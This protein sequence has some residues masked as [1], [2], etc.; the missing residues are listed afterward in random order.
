MFLADPVQGQIK[1]SSSNLPIV[2]INTAQGAAII[3]EPK[4]TADMKIIF[5]GAGK[6]NYVTDPGNVYN[7]KIGIE[8]RG[9]YSASLPQKP[10]GIET[11]DASGNKFNVSLLGM[12]P[13][14]DWVLLANYN[15][16]TFLRNLL[17]LIHI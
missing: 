2:I 16:K 3:D 11:R 6:R 9:A 17:S 5:N 8:I 7:G 15:D 14:N 4:I 12:P 10:Y 13:E 1:F